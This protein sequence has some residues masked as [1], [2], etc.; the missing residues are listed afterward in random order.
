MIAAWRDGGRG[1]RA[2]EGEF[3]IRFMYVEVNF[4]KPF[5]GA[6]HFYKARQTSY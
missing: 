3:A 4:L 5:T 6:T 2:R 1:R